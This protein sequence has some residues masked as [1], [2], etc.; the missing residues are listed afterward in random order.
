MAID[1]RPAILLGLG[2][3]GKGVVAG[4]LDRIAPQLGLTPEIAGAVVGYLV[5]D[6]TAEGSIPNLVAKGV[7]IGAVSQLFKEPVERLAKGLPMVGATATTAG[8]VITLGGG[9][10]TPEEY[11]KKKYGV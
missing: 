2:A 9:A 1:L 6:R 7:F 3:A 5:A 11:I 8:G 10:I 4:M